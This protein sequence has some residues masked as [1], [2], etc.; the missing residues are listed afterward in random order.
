MEDFQMSP[1]DLEIEKNVYGWSDE[2][3]RF[4][5]HCE[6]ERRIACREFSSRVSG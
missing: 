3:F 5:V 2:Q 4:L 6:I 1:V